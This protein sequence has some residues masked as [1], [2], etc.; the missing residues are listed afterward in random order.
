MLLPSG[1]TLDLPSYLCG[2][3]LRQQLRQQLRHGPGQC[4]FSSFADRSLTLVVGLSNTISLIMMTPSF[5]YSCCFF[6]DQ[7]HYETVTDA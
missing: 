5:G 6:L 4:R 1:E 7:S 2:H 3:M